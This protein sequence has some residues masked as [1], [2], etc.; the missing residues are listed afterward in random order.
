MNEELDTTLA[1]TVAEVLRE[2]ELL[3][4]DYEADLAQALQLASEQPL[5]QRELH[6]LFTKILTR[7]RAGRGADGETR[8][9]IA[10]EVR[11]MIDEL[12][13]ESI[14]SI[15]RMRRDHVELEERH[16]LKPRSVRPSPV[17][18]GQRIELREG[19]V[20]VTRLH[21]WPKNHRL[22]LHVNEF[23]KRKGHHPNH[24]ELL[25]I[26]LSHEQFTGVPPKDRIDQFKIRELA[27]SIATNGVR[28]PPIIDWSGTP[29]DGNRR[30][31]ACLYILSNDE[32]D[33]E[34]RQ[35]ARWVKVWQAPE[36]TTP[37][38]IY[39]MVVSLN[40]EKDL[41]EPWPEYV[42]ARQ[43][44][45]EYEKR[46]D[47]AHATDQSPDP[48]KIRREVGK[49]FGIRTD[50][51]T[52]YVRMVEWAEE[53]RSFH[54]DNGRDEA[55]VLHRTN[56]YFQYFYELDTGRGENKLSVTL[57]KNESFK[58]LVFDLLYEDK[59]KRWAQIRD[60][61][62]VF[63]DEDATETLIEAA[64]TPHSDVGR[65]RVEQAIAEARR[66]DISRRQIGAQQR[67]DEFTKWLETEATQETWRKQV[68]LDVLRR[69]QQAMK[70]AIGTVET[71]LDERDVQA[72]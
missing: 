27:D 72:S 23:R 58:G 11:E 26:L 3:A 52:R 15:P 44:F 25:D 71:V 19:F 49:K 31:A 30:I 1:A 60:L 10:Q 13:N 29:Y 70:G 9:E 32:Y 45:E 46:V 43:V 51:V 40:F 22:D 66:H 55:D 54:E 12:V 68:N 21:L 61:R 42:R 50:Q 7:L 63:A 20:D 28:I 33:E 56:K 34:A 65:D 36:E 47:V 5:S 39:H 4:A 24:K 69:F 64:A 67:V 41:K 16:G 6:D 8:A 38:Q 57:D 14:R 48:R 62:K 59:F 17:F 18:L 35:N 37:D 2:A 53:F